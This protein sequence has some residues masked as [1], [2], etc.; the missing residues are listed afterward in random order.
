MVLVR[1]ANDN[2]PVQLFYDAQRDAF[3]GELGLH[4]PGPKEIVSVGTHYSEGRVVDRKLAVIDDLGTS[5]LD[6]ALSAGG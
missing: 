5:V 2:Q 3:F 4:E 6:V 1:G